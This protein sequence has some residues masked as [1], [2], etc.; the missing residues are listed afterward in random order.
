MR[1][2]CYMDSPVGKLQI[3]EK[4]G[5]LTHVLFCSRTGMKPITE[6]GHEVLAKVCGKRVFFEEKQTALLKKTMKELEEYFEGKRREFDIPLCPEGT[7][8][9]LKAWDGL[10]TIPYGETRTYKQMAE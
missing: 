10:R 3:V 8:F 2:G 6:E 1:Y 5:A 4:D 7:E 9:Q